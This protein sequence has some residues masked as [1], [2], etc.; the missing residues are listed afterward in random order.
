MKQQ[1][2]RLAFAAF[3]V[4]LDHGRA[5]QPLT[6]LRPA[7][8]VRV[9][10]A[11]L[12]GLMDEINSDAF[13]LMSPSNDA[14]TEVEM[15]D[16]FEVFL[17]ELVFS[18]N[19]PRV[20]I[21]NKFDVAGNPEFVQ[22]LESK[23]E[24]SQ[25]PE[26][27]VALK[28]LLEIVVDITTRIEVNKLA[29]ERAAAEGSAGDDQLDDEAVEAGRKMTNAEVLKKATQIQTQSTDE[30]EA[31]KTKKTFYDADLTPEIRLSYEKM[32][33]TVLPPYKPGDSPASIVFKH[34][35]QFDAQFVKVLNERAEQGDDDSKVVLE[36]LATE[37]KRKISNASETLQSVL[38]MGEPMK[39]EGAV[40][41]AAREGKIDEAFLLLLEANAQQA[42]A[43]GASGPAQ[44]MQRLRK[45]S[46]EE[47]DKQASSKEIVLIRKLLRTED[48][49]DR[50]K[51][52]EDAFT[53]RETLLVPGTAENA[54]KAMEGEAPEQEKPLPDVPPPEF[55]NACK[56]VLLNFG[57]LG[58]DDESRGDLATR[59]KKLAAEAEVV[60]TRIYGKG[61]TVKEQQDKVWD[62]QTTS[63]FDLERMEIEAERNGETAPW[64][65]PNADDDMFMP[66]FDQDGRMQVG[67]S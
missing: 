31:T 52:L 59:I 57:N 27:R 26:E 43:A 44:L 47:K 63:I 33:K 13:D 22:W 20:D 55:I 28:D 3:V 15:N 29:D 53:P 12:F 60:A 38:S 32:V 40:V 37:Q 21:M 9:P 23:V 45:R 36:A 14:E 42:E 49:G 18:T 16:S 39:M 10:T 2:T 58:S 56:A 34:Y 11:P 48:A 24:N 64:A 25:D 17:A 66:G 41:K 30:I 35:E 4:L 8:I 6:H 50:E 7:A 67:G 65:N 62:E 46:I 54:Q 51:I 61:M 1:P 19:D 5:F